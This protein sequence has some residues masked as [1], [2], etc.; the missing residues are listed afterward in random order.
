MCFQAQTVLSTN[1]SC[2]FSGSDYSSA[3]ALSV[4]PPVT[5]MSSLT[6]QLAVKLSLSSLLLVFLTDKLNEASITSS[7]LWYCTW[8]VATCTAK[9]LPVK[10]QDLTPRCQKRFSVCVKQDSRHSSKYNASATWWYQPL[11]QCQV[12]DCL[13]LSI[14]CIRV[15]VGS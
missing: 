8:S 12:C 1:T 4:A 13:N 9:Q 2:L 14:V 3:G 11:S 5:G 6:A 10:W 7:S 15:A